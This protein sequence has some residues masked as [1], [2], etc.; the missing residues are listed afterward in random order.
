MKPNWQLSVPQSMLF[1]FDVI[2]FIYLYRSQRAIDVFADFPP[3]E[4][5]NKLNA[6][7]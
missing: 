7:H 5:V 1:L 3:A 4:L 6:K 2:G